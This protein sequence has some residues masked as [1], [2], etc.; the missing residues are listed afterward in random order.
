MRKK[1]ILMAALFTIFMWTM[2]ATAQERVGNTVIENPQFSVNNTN[3]I[4]IDKVELLPDST[5]L[6]MTAY[7]SPKSWVVINSETY[8]RV[9]GEKL[10][11]TSAEGITPDKKFYSDETNQ[12]HFV[13]NF[14]AV[15]ADAQ[16]LDFFESDCENC[17]KIWEVALTTESSQQIAVSTPID[18]QNWAEIPDDGQPLVTPAWKSGKAKIKGFIRG[19]KPEM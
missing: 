9:K 17:F 19:F 8:I 2:P 4:T 6:H 16:T 3:S 18:I 12:T 13:L 15:P 5:R 14:P 7:H 10:T 11:M 1:S